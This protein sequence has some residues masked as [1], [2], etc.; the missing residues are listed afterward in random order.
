MSVIT[1]VYETAVIETSSLRTPVMAREIGRYVA[2]VVGA[3]VLAATL[4][5]PIS[6]LPGEHGNVYSGISFLIALAWFVGLNYV[7]K[8]ALAFTFV[9]MGV[10]GLVGALLSL[11]SPGWLWAVWGVNLGAGLLRLMFPRWFSAVP[12]DRSVAWTVFHL[13]II[14]MVGGL[15]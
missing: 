5:L 9:G 3:M 6:L 13:S 1:Q 11:S 12:A 7:R 2:A 10:F 14:L 15:G 8:P 4:V